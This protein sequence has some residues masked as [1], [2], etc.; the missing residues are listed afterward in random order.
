MPTALQMGLAR[1]VDAK[2]IALISRSF[3]ESGL[4]WSWT[5]ERVAKHIRCPDTV[6]LTAR[7][8]NR[9]VGFAIMYFG[10]DNAHLNLL[11]VRPNYQR[12]GI[13]RNLVTWLEQSARVAG[14]TAV[15]LEVRVSN[16]AARRFYRS[17]SYWEVVAIPNYYQRKESAVLMMHNL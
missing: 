14:I 17:L 13:G 2:S 9:L 16:K 8:Q 5:P 6:V 1:L 11:G 15:H 3:I 12:R 4:T 10:D 7:E